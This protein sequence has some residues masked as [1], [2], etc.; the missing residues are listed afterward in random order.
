[1]ATITAAQVNGPLVPSTTVGG[2]G[3]NPQA[4]YNSSDLY[5]ST[6]PTTVALTPLMATLENGAGGRIT[7]LA[8]DYDLGAYAVQPEE[9]GLDGHIVYYSLDGFAWNKID[10]LSGVGTPGKLTANVPV[11]NWEEGS[12]LYLLW[13][14]DNGPASDGGFTLDNVHL[15]PTVEKIVIGRN[16][17]YN[18]NHTVGGAPNGSLSTTGNYFLEGANPTAF[19]TTDVVNFSQNGSA[20]IDVPADVTTGGVVVSN[21]TGTYTI[22]GAGKIKGPFTKSN[23]G[24]VVFTSVNDF[25]KSTITGGTVETRAGALGGGSVVR[26]HHA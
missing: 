16:L 7:S 26:L 6:R 1:V 9:P 4:R 22:G 10:A 14:D 15:V 23:A 25:S 20:T 12:P 19:A 5:V 3:L 13:V 17:V 8:I 2:S 18:L 24:N 11:T 21:T